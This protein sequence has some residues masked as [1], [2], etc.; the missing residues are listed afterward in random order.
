MREYVA[1]NVT[2]QFPFDPYKC[3]E[4][5]MEKVVRALQS[6]AN[7][8]L[9]SPTGTGKTLCLLCATLAW[10][11]AYMARRQLAQAFSRGL[12]DNFNDDLRRSLDMTVS[13]LPDKGKTIKLALI[14]NCIHYVLFKIT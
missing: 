1:N 8:L 14:R 13:A 12:V 7:A 9:E 4:I 11:E 2:I 3:Q 6:S 5:F 10:R